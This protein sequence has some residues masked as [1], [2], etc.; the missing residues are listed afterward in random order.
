M[1]ATVFI[2][3]S[4]KDLERDPPTDLS[5][6]DATIRASR[7]KF[8][9]KLRDT[10]AAALRRDKRFKVF[11][12]VRGGLRPGDVWRSGLHDALR[13]CSAG[14]V[15]LTPESLES[16]W[17]LKEATILSWRAFMAEPMVLIPIVLDVS[18]AQL[19]ERGFG[20]LDLDA[21][22]WLNVNGT[23]EAEIRRVVNAAADVLRRKYASLQAG[24]RDLTDTEAWI[25]TLAT[26]LGNAIGTST[27]NL[28]NRYLTG[29]CRELDIEPADAKRFNGDPLVHVAAH[30]LLADSDQII[31]F[32]RHVGNPSGAQRQELQQ[33]VAALWVDPASAAC[34]LSKDTKV[35]VMDTAET[36]SAREYI[37]RAFCNR[38]P[39]DRLIQP[40]DVTGG[41]E[42]DVLTEIEQCLRQV[43]PIEDDAALAQDLKKNGRVFVVLGPGSTRPN[44]LDRVTEDYPQLTFVVAAGS[45][46]KAKLG[47]WSDKA[48]VL[49]PLLQPTRER[50]AEL[51]RNRLAMFAKGT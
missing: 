47:T 25:E 15:L 43:L 19:K 4:C 49:R 9:R 51:F 22:Q 42:S 36:A 1:A 45:N 12:D 24:P 40:S 37:A 8:C 3:H 35:I 16:H 30:V 32:L 21:I 7:L 18:R 14:I 48:L 26:T 46:P 13:T 20:A 41:T 17:V 2:S 6:E 34:M 11:L 39:A 44:V 5:E 27:I 33:A 23:D 10:L 28:K 29:M 50:A 31:R 38:F